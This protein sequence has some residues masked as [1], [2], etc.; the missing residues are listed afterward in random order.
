MTALRGDKIV[1]KVDDVILVG[2]RTVTR[3]TEMDEVESTTADTDGYAKTFKPIRYGQT[4]SVEGLRETGVASRETVEDVLTKL[5]NGTSFTLYYGGIETGDSYW[6]SDA[7]FLSL[8]ESNDYAG[9]QEYSGEIRVN[10]EPTKD[11]VS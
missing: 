9:L 10:G 8:E 5:Q 4:V 2:R 7:F 3:S 6:T 1:V 11:T